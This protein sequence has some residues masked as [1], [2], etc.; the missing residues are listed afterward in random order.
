MRRLILTTLG[1]EAVVLTVALSS[2]V[3]DAQTGTATYERTDSSGVV[4]IESH[5]AAWGP[6][7]LEIEVQPQ[8]TIGR[9]EAGP[10]QF[11]FLSD[12]AIMSNG[13]IL[14]AEFL[15]GELR[16]FSA[17][18]E[19][20]QTYG[21]KGD[22]PGEFRSLAA[23]FEYAADSL[24]AWDS[25]LRRA[26]IFPKGP[27]SL[28]VVGGAK[29]G[30]FDV[31]GLLENGSFLLYSAGGSFRRDLS[32]GRQ[33]IITDVLSMDTHNG[34]SRR[35]VR[36]PDRERVVAPDG[37]APMSVPL[38]YAIQAV[39]RDGFYWA[40]PDRYEIKF[41]DPDGKLRRILR[42]PIEP[43]V[44][45]PSMIAEYVES[46]LERVRRAGGEGAVPGARK[47]LEEGPFGERVPLFES[48]FVDVDQRLWVSR[49][50]WP[51]RERSRHWSVFSNEGAWLG[52]VNAPERL[53]ILDA[54]GDLVLGIWR[55]DVDVPHVRLHRIARP[56]R[57][58]R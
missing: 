23:A 43:S 2:C 18:G 55:D 17:T 42:R 6:D 31:F 51:S 50:N 44:V 21:R 37:N 3:G 5:A 28:R 20:L 19:H 49:S 16:L 24:A 36:L 52:D 22:G 26:T 45:E 32:P 11:A 1:L 30:N 12:G 56:G 13:D 48:A 40:T 38:R 41:F 10:Y 8:V 54:R 35:I 4:I 29:E 57:S 46:E 33:W 47:S 39:A 25:R 9:E 14:I 15:A 53:Q 34:S 27:G 7:T 58:A